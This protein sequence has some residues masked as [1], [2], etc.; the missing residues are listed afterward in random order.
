MGGGTSRR[1]E[2]LENDNEHEEGRVKY[3]R[4]ARASASIGSTDESRGVCTSE[5]LR[6]FA[7]RVLARRCPINRSS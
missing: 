5:R 6:I 1:M 4:I 7:N 3:G 2:K